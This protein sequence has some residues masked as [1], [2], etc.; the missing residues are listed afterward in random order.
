MRRLITTFRRHP[1]ALLALLA[2]LGAGAAACSSQPQWDDPKGSRSPAE[3]PDAPPP[4]T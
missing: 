1:L 2:A 3:E 4:A